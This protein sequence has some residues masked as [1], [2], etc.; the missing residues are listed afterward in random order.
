MWAV[1]VPPVVFQCRLQKLEFLQWHSS[2]GLFQ[3]N[4]S[5][6]VPVYPTRIRSVAQ[7]YPSV[8]WV[9]QWHFSGIPVYTGPASVHWLRVRE[10][11]YMCLHIHA[12]IWLLVKVI[13]F[14]KR[15]PWFNF[16]ILHRCNQHFEYFVRICRVSLHIKVNHND[17]TKWQRCVRGIYLEI[18]GVL[19]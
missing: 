13:S 3:L 19:T 4:L 16:M 9:N 10:V 17:V 2:V 1:T 12:F 6:G 8:H 11:M 15:R 14:S 18:T 7:W 5:S